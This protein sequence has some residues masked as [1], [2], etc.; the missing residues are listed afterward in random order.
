MGWGNGVQL[1]NSETTPN[2]TT[3]SQN[4]NDNEQG[5][6]EGDWEMER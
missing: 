6:L 4:G 1:Q 5:G 3:K 2:T